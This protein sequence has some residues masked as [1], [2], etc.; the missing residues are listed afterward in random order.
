MT[1]NV[2]LVAE[3]DADVRELLAFALEAAGYAT[4][5]AGDGRTAA[6]ML[7]STRP[8]GV[9]AD[10]RMPALNGMDLCRLVRSTPEWFN[11]AFL[12]VSANTHQYD[13]DAGISAGADR[14]LPKPLSPRRLVAELAAVLATRSSRPAP[15]TP[16]APAFRLA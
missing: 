12:L 3:D 1:E 7:G 2:V 13:V 15:A 14:Y 6:K 5:A 8:V 4:V 16:V 9:I 10:V 11:T